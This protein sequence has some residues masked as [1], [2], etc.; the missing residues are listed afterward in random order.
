MATLRE[1]IWADDDFMQDAAP[2]TGELKRNAPKLGTP[3]HDAPKQ[4]IA[5]KDVAKSRPSE[6]DASVKK[7]LNKQMLEAL[8]EIANESFN[9]EPVKQA[10][11]KQSAQKSDTVQHQAEKEDNAVTTDVNVAVNVPVKKKVLPPHLARKAQGSD[12]VA[13]NAPTRSIEE[14]PAPAPVPDGVDI[15]TTKVPVK[16]V[17]PPHLSKKAQD[18]DAAAKHAPTRAIKEN[19]APAAIPGG[20]NIAAGPSAGVARAG[21]APGAVAT[22][23]EASQLGSA[24]PVRQDAVQEAVAMPR[25]VMKPGFNEEGLPLLFRP[26][27]TQV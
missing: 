26:T 1:S 17:L 7:D 3:K 9:L 14:N 16:K 19:A 8:E 23:P 15:P 20:V 4:D 10:S 22:R 2:K 13:K 5:K 27:A 18:N 11:E 24:P 12:A 25:A 6:S 21:V